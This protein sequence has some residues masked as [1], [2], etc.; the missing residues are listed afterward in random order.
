MSILDRVKSAFAPRQTQS[1]DLIERAM[2]APF[3]GGASTGLYQNQ[4]GARK[5][6]EEILQLYRESPR[7]RAVTH[8]IASSVAKTEWR[9]YARRAPGS[10]KAAPSYVMDRDLATMPTERR[11]EA[12]MRAVADGDVDEIEMHPCIRI[13]NRPNRTMSGFAARLVTQIHLD[14]VGDAFW[15]VDDNESG[16]PVRLWPVPPSWVTKVPTPDAQEFHVNFSGFAGIVPA[17]KMI[18][19]RDIDPSEPYGRGSGIGLSLGDELDID[20]HAAKTVAGWFQNSGMPSMLVSLKG[21]NQPS[22]E[23]ARLRWDRTLKGFRRAYQT[24]FTGADINVQRLDTSFKDMALVDIR[25]EARDVVVQTF[26]IPPEK[27]AIIENSNKST[28][29]AADLIF[30]KDVVLPRLE[31]M[32]Q[33]FQSKLIPRF[34]PRLIIDFVNP[35]PDDRETRN[36]VATQLPAIMTIDEHR[37]RAG[38]GPLNDG[39]GSGFLVGQVWVRSLVDLQ[40]KTNVPLYGYHLSAGLLTNNEARQVLGLQPTAEPWGQDRSVGTF[41]PPI[42]SPPE[43]GL[44][45][46]E[47]DPLAGFSPSEE[48]VAAEKARRTQKKWVTVKQTRSVINAIRLDDVIANIGP[49]ARDLAA[50]WGSAIT[51]IATKGVRSAFESTSTSKFLADY[52]AKRLAAVN[53]S[54]K[55]GVR[56]ALEQWDGESKDALMKSVRDV[57][58]KAK[59]TRAQLISTSDVLHV[60]QWAANEAMKAAGDIVEMKEWL[61]VMDGR[62]REAH[63]ALDGQT[64]PVDVPFVVPS[65]E[66]SGY[67]TD[68]PGNF[69]EPALDYNCILPGNRVEGSFST[70]IISRYVGQAVEVKTRNGRVLR[71]TP[72]HP[73]MTMRGLIRANELREGDKVLC[74]GVD[75]ERWSTSTAEANDIN[76]VPPRVEDVARAIGRLHPSIACRV[77]GPDLHG[78]GISIDGDV[79]V[80]TSDSLLLSHMD[81]SG[82]KRNGDGD[83]VP[84]EMRDS[85]LASLGA[86]THLAVARPVL[87]SA[88]PGFRELT[89]NGGVSH[90]RPLEFLSVGSSSRL[91]AVVMETLGDRSSIDPELVG[92][93]VD[94]G[95]G[96]VSTDDVVDVGVFEYSGHVY[97][98][99][100]VTGLMVVEGLLVSNCRCY[101]AP[102]FVTEGEDKAATDARRAKAWATEDAR[103]R[104]WEA[105]MSDALV[106]VFERQEASV[107]SKLNE[108][109]D[110]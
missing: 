96:I 42:E 48:D 3:G 83:L 59:T 107:I 105:K 2:D 82:G 25:K 45:P 71:V 102:F 58:S 100:S 89:S 98:L 104:F 22:V 51:E 27:L 92:K 67:Q 43:P 53:E 99:S 86:R 26:G 52:N 81:A 34:D 72:N 106:D 93:L 70:S 38:L 61:A 56:K 41:T 91:D 88:L 68:A 36:A 64:V 77:T 63:R 18:W 75:I 46:P 103:M 39:S 10:T 62:T 19:F 29:D 28:I 55:D 90:G 60:G 4:T 40:A 84:A 49:I 15:I 79:H 1:G 101:A 31:L 73:V 95:A 66:W 94:A 108:V 97:D 12:I 85:F 11:R 76:D 54:T 109:I 9:L 24:Y 57:F 80:A 7:L 30:T 5:G 6:S 78:D 69:G 65:G 110:E 87:S 50:D 74:N 35:V 14:L 33:E 20:E 8:K 21:A 47:A 32:R 37:A 16:M 13:L 23:R 44:P 17:E